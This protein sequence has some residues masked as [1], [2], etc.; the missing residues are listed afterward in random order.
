MKKT[1]TLLALAGTFVTFAA[2]AFAQHSHGYVGDADGD[3][4]LDMVSA[5]TGSGTLLLTLPT[6]ELAYA[7][8]GVYADAGYNF[9]GSYTFSGLHGSQSAVSN[10]QGALSGTKIYMTLYAVSGPAGGT[11]AFFDQGILS[12]SMETGTT[13]GTGSFVL[14]EELYYELDPSDPYGHIH[15]RRFAADTFGTYTVTWVISNSES[16]GTRDSLS[17]PNVGERFFTQTFNAV[18][19]PT[20]AA[21]VVIALGAGVACFRRKKTA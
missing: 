16:I 19:E 9:N 18:P 11:F 1:L 4:Y 21:L 8:T 12:L 15:G 13:G 14:T 2:P 7:D 10:P 5:D 6:R 3:G 17:N 20:T